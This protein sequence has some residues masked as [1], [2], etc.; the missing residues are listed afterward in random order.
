M[1]SSSV[2]RAGRSVLISAVL[3]AALALVGC[4][5][6]HAVNPQKHEPTPHYTTLNWVSTAVLYGESEGKHD[7][8]L[9]FV[10]KATCPACQLLKARTLTDST[11]IQI[12]GESFNIANIDVT[13]DTL[14]S[15]RDSVVTV[16]HLALAIYGVEYVPTIIVLDRHGNEKTRLA[17]YYPADKFA[18]E[19]RG[20][21]DSTA[22]TDKRRSSDVTS[23]VL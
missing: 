7:L 13:V 19:L 23:C 2:E 18:S 22:V 20:L 8:S 9:L 17:D 5:A 21:L 12:L 16:R 14:V 1:R 6:D 4:S 3:A 11:V 10:L 15:Y